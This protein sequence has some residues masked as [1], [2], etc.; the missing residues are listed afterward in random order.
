MDAFLLAV[1]LL[2]NDEHTLTVQRML[3]TQPRTHEACTA[4]EANPA[5][6]QKHLKPARTGCEEILLCVQVGWRLDTPTPPAKG[7]KR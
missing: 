1:A 7:K 2:C 3:E 5:M 4:D 6:R